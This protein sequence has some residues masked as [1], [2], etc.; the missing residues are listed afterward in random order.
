MPDISDM[1]HLLSSEGGTAEDLSTTDRDA[2]LASHLE[3]VNHEYAR[4]LKMYGEALH[5][6]LDR[7]DSP[8][9]RIGQAVLRNI[10]SVQQLS[11]VRAPSYE[12]AGS[13]DNC[14][15]LWFPQ[16]S[17]Q[18]PEQVAD[19]TQF[20]RANASHGTLEIATA[21]GQSAIDGSRWLPREEFI[22]GFNQSQAAIGSILPI[23]PHGE[24][25]I[26]TVSAELYVDLVAYDGTTL[27]P[28]P[29]ANLLYAQPGSEDLPLRGAAVS[30]CTAGLSLH[31]SQ[32]SARNT[33]DFVSSYA[34]SDGQVTHDLAPDGKFSLVN[35]VRIAPETL[36]LSVFVDVTCFAGAEQD[37][38]Q[39]KSSFAVFDCRNKPVGEGIG[40][41]YL[42]PARLR[43]HRISARLCEYPNL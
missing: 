17:M 34:N 28:E 23:L 15:L 12:S 13:A 26:L 24:G 42:P 16:F 19:V 11:S 41:Y 39:Y 25:A 10:G 40:C 32:G 29:A 5:G 31:G 4:H 20:T 6:L 33:I 7:A 43:V 37:E 21:S 27:P 38:S 30:W 36:N 3:T 35:S 1:R 8:R 9:E 2:L 22:L 14:I 18:S